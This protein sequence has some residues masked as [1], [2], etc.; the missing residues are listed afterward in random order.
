VVG[1]RGRANRA[2]ARHS[3]L[4]FWVLLILLAIERIVERNESRDRFT[5]QRQLDFPTHCLT[6]DATSR[7]KP[8]ATNAGQRNIA[9]E[10]RETLS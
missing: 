6:E 4:Q 10:R 9:Q 5:A 2:A 1:L 8:V 7:P 3:I